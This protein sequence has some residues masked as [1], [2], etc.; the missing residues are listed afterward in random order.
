MIEKERKEVD[1]SMKKTQ[2]NLYEHI[3]QIQDDSKEK[4]ESKSVV[5]PE[6]IIKT[7]IVKTY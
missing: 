2:E 1:E 4:E 5:I 3:K 7:P 6:P